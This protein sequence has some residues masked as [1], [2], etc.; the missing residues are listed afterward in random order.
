MDKEKT[1][2]VKYAILFCFLALIF[3][4]TI[5]SVVFLGKLFFGGSNV[6]T[7]K[8]ISDKKYE[9]YNSNSKDLTNIKKA[10]FEK[11][12]KFFNSIMDYKFRKIMSHELKA[13]EIEFRICMVEN[14]LSDRQAINVVRNTYYYVDEASRLR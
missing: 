7:A 2:K 9:K 11:E 5:S 10:C 1:V 14:G 4:T 6:A 8:E 13:A 12:S 3:I